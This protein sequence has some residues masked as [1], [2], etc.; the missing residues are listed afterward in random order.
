MF[1][2]NPQAMFITNPQVVLVFAYL[3]RK[4]NFYLYW[5]TENWQER[6]LVFISKSANLG[7]SWVTPNLL[8]GQLS[9]TS[10]VPWVLHSYLRI[11][12][13]SRNSIQCLKEADVCISTKMTRGQK[14]SWTECPDD[15]TNVTEIEVFNFSIILSCIVSCQLVTPPL[16]WT[17]DFTGW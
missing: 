7:A 10:W 14:C 5:E 3:T 4:T 16:S 2:T 15:R 8:S 1:I 12:V 9:A 17:C 6:G 11:Q 13:L